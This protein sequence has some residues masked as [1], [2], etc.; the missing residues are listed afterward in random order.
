MPFNKDGTPWSA[1]TGHLAL[2][3]IRRQAID[4]LK[5]RE[6]RMSRGRM[7]AENHYSPYHEVQKE[8][9]QGSTFVVDPLLASLKHTGEE[10]ILLTQ[11]RWAE[12]TSKPQDEKPYRD[13]LLKRTQGDRLSAMKAAGQEVEDSLTPI[14]DADL[15]VMPPMSK[16]K[17]KE[18]VLIG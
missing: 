2:Q 17:A 12:F 13:K 16:P 6:E 9:G 7:N 5:A 10:T 14:P 11:K 1:D 3:D 15:P 18:P 8:N 4:D